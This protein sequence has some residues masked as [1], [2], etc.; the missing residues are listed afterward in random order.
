MYKK[1]ISYYYGDRIATTTDTPIKLLN[2]IYNNKYN[3]IYKPTL[4][5]LLTN[6]KYYEGDPEDAWKLEHNI[7]LLIDTRKPERRHSGKKQ[8]HNKNWRRQGT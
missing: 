5:E 2:N 3:D 6:N 8:K 4:K 1:G 7:N